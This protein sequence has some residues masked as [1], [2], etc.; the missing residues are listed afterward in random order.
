MKTLDAKRV[1]EA[2]LICAAQPLPL[3]DLV[4]L[5]GDEVGADTVKSLLG[6]LV[7]ECDGRGVELVSLAGGWRYQTRPEMGGFLARLNPDRPPRYSRAVL[8]RWRSSPTA[9]RHEGDI[10][11]IRGV[12][13]GTQ[14]VKQ[15]ED[16]AGSRR[17]ATRSAGRPALLATTRAFLDDL[18]LQ[19]LAQLRRSPAPMPV[20]QSRTRSAR[21]PFGATLQSQLRFEPGLSDPALEPHS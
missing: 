9:S 10:E 13:V 12:A 16:R 15:L 17:S 8:R 11:D 19:S 21:V 18:G 3:H 4:A 14:I 20:C 5:F 6:E 7:R 1:L 2:A